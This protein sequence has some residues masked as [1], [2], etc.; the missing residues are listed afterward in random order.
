M[1][2]LKCDNFEHPHNDPPLVPQKPTFALK[3]SLISFPS[4]TE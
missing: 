1:K 2:L 4:K 3:M